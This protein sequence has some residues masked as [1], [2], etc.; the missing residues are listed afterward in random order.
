MKRLGTVWY[1]DL[2]NNMITKQARITAA[3]ANEE[4]TE[5][6]SGKQETRINVI[7]IAIVSCSCCYYGCC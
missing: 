1:L 4:E 3:R 5:E 2:D 6:R 7:F